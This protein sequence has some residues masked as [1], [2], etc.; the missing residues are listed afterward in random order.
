MSSIMTL[1]VSTPYRGRFVEKAKAL[2]T[3][4]QR[5]GVMWVSG[6][7]KVECHVCGCKFAPPIFEPDQP[8]HWGECP[9]CHLPFIF[10]L[11][12]AKQP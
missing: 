9:G 6:E 1:I 10:R 3:A 7:D 4:G 12:G 5:V 2:V 11:V 8:D